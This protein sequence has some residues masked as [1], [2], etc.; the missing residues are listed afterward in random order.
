MLWETALKV[1][2]AQ[3]QKELEEL[4]TQMRNG[5]D[6][7]KTSLQRCLCGSLQVAQVTR[8]QGELF[9]DAQNFSTIAEIA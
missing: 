2:E 5:R 9:L 8:R 3:L 7:R 1:T 6:A 4:S